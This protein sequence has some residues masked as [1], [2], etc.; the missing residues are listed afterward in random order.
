MQTYLQ[1]KLFWGCGRMDTD[2]SVLL[3]D[4]DALRRRARGDRRGYW[5]PLLLFG[6]LTLAAPLVYGIGGGNQVSGSYP[7]YQF[8]LARLGPFPGSAGNSVAVGLYWLGV[9]VVGVLATVLWYRLR[10]RRVG[11]QA[12]T[13]TY[14]WGALGALVVL[15]VLVP[16]AGDRIMFGWLGGYNQSS[17]WFGLAMALFGIA[18]VWVSVVLRER[19][20]VRRIGLA[21]GAVVGMLGLQILVTFATTHGFGGLLVIAVGLLALAW[22]ERSVLCGVVA[23]LFVAASLLANLYDM[24]NVLLGSAYT[25]DVRAITFDNLLLPAAVLIIGGV[26]ALVVGARS[27]TAAVR[28]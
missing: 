21:V 27:S 26:V 15:V 22:M 6:V 8:S 2:P 18:L 13:G 4:M 11:L 1:R 10:A 20:V 16:Y 25:D 28:Q 24:E 7:W 17:F 9:I 5:L 12:R 14:L 19:Q 3:D 23:V